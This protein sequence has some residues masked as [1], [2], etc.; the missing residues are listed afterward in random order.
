[1]PV[2]FKKIHAGFL[3]ASLIGPAGIF[4]NFVQAQ[5]IRAS[6]QKEIMFYD[7]INPGNGR[8]S[9]KAT[10][11][12]VTYGLQF[13]AAAPVANQV[14]GVSSITS[15]LASLAWLT[16][17]SGIGS[18]ANGQV[19]YWNGPTS[20]T[21]SNDL[22]WDATNKRLGIGTSNPS[23]KLSINEPTS[24]DVGV[25]MIARGGNNRRSQLTFGVKTTSSNSLG[26]AIGS[27]GNLGGGLILN[28]QTN[29][30]STA[31]PH[32]YINTTGE[33]CVNTTTDNGNYKV[34]I[35]GDL[36]ATSARFINVS[37]SGYFASLSI[38]SDGTLTTAASDQRLKRNI[39]TISNPLQKV[40][41]LRGVTYNWRDSTMPQRMM[42]MI[43][44]EVLKVT[45]ELVFQN[46]TTGYYGINYGETS[47]LLVE[48]IK[49]QQQ[50]IQELKTSLE[51]QRQEILALQQE[52]GLL[53]KQIEKIPKKN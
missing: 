43:A 53:K 14:L 45:P 48:A 28:G 39:E 47:G 16:P 6:A 2:F 24:A 1:M 38:K 49:A 25:S 8:L 36:Y 42:G 41:A 27:D 26:G 23:D 44:Q 50:I 29:D 20:Q 13:P 34:Q 3:L 40:M 21:G 35:N 18:G 52:I 7:P 10:S 15:G 32:V 51:S 5:T 17:L 11:G 46:K 31:Q 12:T 37:N 4:S 22:F 19:A 9:L 30:I 33:M